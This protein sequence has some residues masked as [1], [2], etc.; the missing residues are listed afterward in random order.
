MCTSTLYSPFPLI[1]VKE[2]G[3]NFADLCIEYYVE[4]VLYN[5]VH[6]PS[7]TSNNNHTSIVMPI[8]YNNYNKNNSNNF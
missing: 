4:K 7:K 3:Q 8:S 6:T 1:K 2:F 5:T